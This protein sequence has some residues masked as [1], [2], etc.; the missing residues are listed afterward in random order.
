M[1]H[2]N[3]SM[4][5]ALLTSA[6]VIAVAGSPVLAAPAHSAPGGCEQFAFAGLTTIRAVQDGQIKDLTF[7]SNEPTFSGPITSPANPRS[8]NGTANLDPG[9]HFEM[10]ASQEN[11]LLNV[12]GDVGPDNKIHGT[13]TLQD[14]EKSVSLPANSVGAVK[15]AK[16]APKQGPTVEYSPILGGLNVHVTD[17]SGTTLTGSRAHF[18]WRRIPPRT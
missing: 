6:F 9:G 10:N 18:V 2:D 1:S 8:V 14:G 13:M 17:R 3:S 4:R 7:T 12:G 5:K 15:C 16:E 11:V